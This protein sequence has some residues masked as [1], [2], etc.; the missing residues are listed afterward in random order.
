ME[1]CGPEETLS[2]LRSL[3]ASRTWP[4][5]SK[6]RDKWKVSESLVMV[7]FIIQFPRAGPVQASLV[8]GVAVT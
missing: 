6:G 5:E 8:S 1:F 3:I 4:Q 2:T 7:L